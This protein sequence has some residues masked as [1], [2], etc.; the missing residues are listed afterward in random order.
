MCEENKF[1]ELTNN[2]TSFIH[3]KYP[4]YV[5]TNHDISID[6]QFKYLLER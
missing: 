3:W 1:L 6:V 4:F 2:D 5:I